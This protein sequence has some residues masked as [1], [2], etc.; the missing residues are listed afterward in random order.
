MRGAVT[1]Q[2][3]LSMAEPIPRKI[4][5][6][7]IDKL[8]DLFLMV[9]FPMWKWRVLLL[10]EFAIATKY[11]QDKMRCSSENGINKG[12]HLPPIIQSIIF[13]KDVMAEWSWKKY[14]SKSNVIMHYTPSHA[15]DHLC[16]TW[17]DSVQNC[18][19]YRADT[20]CGTDG[21]K[22]NLPP[23]PHTHTHHPSTRRKPI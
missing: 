6:Q 16:L 11:L 2:R 10:D 7:R 3:L 14:R 4:P 15:N 8:T 13:K 23:P 18:R 17:R 12:V 21:N 5:P 1:M 20:E 22:Y 9:L 19:S